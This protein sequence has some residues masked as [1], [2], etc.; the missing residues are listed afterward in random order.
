M[1]QGTKPPFSVPLDPEPQTLS[2]KCSS[3]ET[4]RLTCL[5][6]HVLA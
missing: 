2:E 4:E 1:N 6:A 3:V 5:G